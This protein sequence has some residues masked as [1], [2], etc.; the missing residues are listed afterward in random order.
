MKGGSNYRC[1]GVDV[2][3]EIEGPHKADRTDFTTYNLTLLLLSCR[4]GVAAAAEISLRVT[5]ESCEQSDPIRNLQGDPRGVY[6]AGHRGFIF[7]N[8]ALCVR[9][10]QSKISNS[11]SNSDEFTPK[12]NF[13][14][15]VLIRTTRSFE[16]LFSKRGRGNDQSERSDISLLRPH[17]AYSNDGG[18]DGHGCGLSL[19]DARWKS[20]G[21]RG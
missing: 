21:F 9:E 6:W 8:P 18:A 10:E 13:E 16:L 20:Y 12:L 17:H 14:A 5:L 15:R 4:A 1:G 3:M 7:M 11:S 2:R 19:I